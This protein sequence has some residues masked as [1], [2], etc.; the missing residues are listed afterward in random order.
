MLEI[1]R[2]LSLGFSALVALAAVVVL[3]RAYL[4]LDRVQKQRRAQETTEEGGEAKHG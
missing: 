4:L 1:V 2:M 3:I